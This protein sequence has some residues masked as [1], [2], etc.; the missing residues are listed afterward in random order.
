[1]HP[2]FTLQASC[3]KLEGSEPE[4]KLVKPPLKILSHLFSRSRDIMTSSSCLS[5]RLG[6]RNTEYVLVMIQIW[7]DLGFPLLNYRNIVIDVSKSK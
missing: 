2:Q 3:Y 4:V 5:A 7:E 6:T 1:M